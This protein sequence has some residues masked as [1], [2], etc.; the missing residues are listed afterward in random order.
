MLMLVLCL[1]LTKCWQS[2]DT[3]VHMLYY[4]YGGT[5][6]TDDVK[7]KVWKIN[8]I[9]LVSFKYVCDINYLLTSNSNA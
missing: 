4:H 5:A 9:K 8:D 1:V 2:Q 6:Q 3:R 7:T